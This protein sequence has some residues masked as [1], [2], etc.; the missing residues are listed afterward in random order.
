MEKI[1]DF[2]GSYDVREEGGFIGKRFVYLLS[3]SWLEDK[4][5]LNICLFIYYYFLKILILL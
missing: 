4:M 5:G 2:V 1:M 3:Y